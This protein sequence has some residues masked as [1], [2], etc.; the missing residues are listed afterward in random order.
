MLAVVFCI[1]LSTYLCWLLSF[2]YIC[3][4]ILFCL[5]VVFYRHLSTYLCWLLSFVYVFQRIFV[6]CCL[7]YTFF[8]VSLLTVVSCIHLQLYL[9][10]TISIVT[11][12]FVYI[13]CYICRDCCLLYC[14][15]FCCCIC[16]GCFLL[17]TFSVVSVVAV[18]S[19]ILF[20]L[21]L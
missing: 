13:F 7:L 4:R 12:V 21:Y 10:V 19:I 20:L 9:R 16:S 3:Q 2:I 11:V 1:H 14:I 15:Y 18:F 8:N 5:F 6:D 17:Y